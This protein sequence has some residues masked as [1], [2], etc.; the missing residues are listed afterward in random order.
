[1]GSPSTEYPYILYDFVSFLR[2]A[3]IVGEGSD[4]SC[5]L[6]ASLELGGLIAQ[7]PSAKSRQRDNHT[8]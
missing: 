2:L 7:R 4:D 3:F 8:V 1:M 6:H 5:Y